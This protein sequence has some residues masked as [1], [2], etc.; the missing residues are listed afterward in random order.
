MYYFSKLN[1]IT[2]VVC[3]RTFVQKMTWIKRMLVSLC[4]KQDSQ[5]KQQKHGCRLRSARPCWS[6]YT[7]FWHPLYTC[8]YVREPNKDPPGRLSGDFRTHKL[9]RCL[10]V[11]RENRSILQHSVK[12][13]LHIRSEEKL[14][15]FVNSVLIH[16][17]KGVVLRNT[18]LWWTT[19]HSTCSICSLGLRSVIYSV[20]L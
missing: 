1:W 13:E 15:A 17:T 3:S 12:C 5:R 18:I 9:E 14:D 2:V 19:R 6:V 16:A 20:R 7:Y 8:V 11:G 4:D 10:L